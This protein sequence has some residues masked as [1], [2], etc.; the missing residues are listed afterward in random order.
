MKLGII[1]FLLCLFSNSAFAV[2]HGAGGACGGDRG[3]LG[4]RKPLDDFERMRNLA[5]AALQSHKTDRFWLRGAFEGLLA[6]YADSLA[7]SKSADKPIDIEAQGSRET[8]KLLRDL[9]LASA[10]AQGVSILADENSELTINPGSKNDLEK[11]ADRMLQEHALTM[12]F[13]IQM[14]VKLRLGIRNRVEEFDSHGT[15]YVPAT[16]FLDMK[17]EGG[18]RFFRQIASAYTENQVN[19]VSGFLYSQEK[20]ADAKP[21][22]AIARS[23][24]V[25]VM[26]VA[27]KK[28]WRNPASI[29]G[30]S[31]TAYAYFGLEKTATW[32]DVL[33]AY[34]ARLERIHLVDM[35]W[36]PIVRDSAK[37]EMEELQYYYRFVVKY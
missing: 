25:G 33:D 5:R 34:W 13:D 21:A 14:E 30:M 3:P 28:P 11:L 17:G 32:N 8:E 29:T 9:A 1:F 18:Q 15:L 22:Q 27:H 4:D 6:E 35:I 26:D 19:G 36:W 7:A 16:I 31:A 10:E 37:Q 20:M 12:N 2:N 24:Y 23:P